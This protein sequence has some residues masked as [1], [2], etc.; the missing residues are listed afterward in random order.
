MSDAGGENTDAQADP[1]A[2]SGENALVRT[3]IEQVLEQVDVPQKVRENLVEQ[4][5]MVTESYRGVLPHPKHFA[6]F[7]RVLPG[8]AERIMQMAEKEQNHR[9][10]REN[11]IMGAE[12]TYATR[13]QLYAAGIMLILVA[14]AVYSLHVG[15]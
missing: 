6:D 4:L 10:G 7:E 13:A 11:K 15:S 12:S 14:G 3:Q 9:H 1:S 5:V 8:C 2:A